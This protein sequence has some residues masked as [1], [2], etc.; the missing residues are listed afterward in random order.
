MAPVLLAATQAWMSA[1]GISVDSGWRW[2]G[3]LAAFAV[4]YVAAGVLFFGSL[5]EET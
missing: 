5:M 1:L 2:L 4:L 3:L